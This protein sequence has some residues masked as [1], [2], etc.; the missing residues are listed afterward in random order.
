MAVDTQIYRDI[1]IANQ[2]VMP[3]LDEGF[4]VEVRQKLEEGGF[5]RIG[6]SANMLN[7]LGK[8][9]AIVYNTDG[10]KPF[11]TPFTVLLKANDRDRCIP[12]AEKALSNLIN[13]VEDI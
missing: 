5:R 8:Y 13:L 1:E 12:E 6:K 7:Y 2:L 4:A 11:E 9:I 10:K 3:L